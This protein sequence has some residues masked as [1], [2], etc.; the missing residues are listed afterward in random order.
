MR[1]QRDTCISTCWDATVV[2]A[3]SVVSNTSY[4][5]VFLEN[6]AII[7]RTSFYEFLQCRL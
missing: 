3:Y 7:S 2:G 5:K 4:N 1:S 6:E